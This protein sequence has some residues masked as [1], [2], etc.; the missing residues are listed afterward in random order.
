MTLLDAII[1][2]DVFIDYPFEEA[3]LRW[4]KQSGKVFRR[5]YGEAEVEIDPTSSLYNDAIRK[6]KQITEEEYL[7]DP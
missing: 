2:G 5:F 7:R 6:G 4:H 1:A 3:K